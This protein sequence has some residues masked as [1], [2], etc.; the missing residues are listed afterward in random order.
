MVK[1][2]GKTNWVL[3]F[4]V[5]VL[6]LVLI[7]LAIVAFFIP[8][9]PVK[10]PVQIANPASTNCI[11]LG[12]ELDIRTDETGG[13]YGVCIKDGKECDEWALFRGEC[14]F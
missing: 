10:N 2:K 13:Q 5:I 4:G 6:I 14:S 12:G 7:S 8:I 11:S 9:S 3:I 1:S